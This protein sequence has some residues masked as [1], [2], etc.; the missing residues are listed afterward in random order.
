MTP[1]E[2]QKLK[3]AA[4]TIADILYQNTPKE[5]VQDFESIELSLR[6]HWLETLGPEL[7]LFFLPKAARLVADENEKLGAV[8]E[9]SP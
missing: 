1:E 9:K 4:E 3:Q 5:K 7:A 8:L 2:R 6:D